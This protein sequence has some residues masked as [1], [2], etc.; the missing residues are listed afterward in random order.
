MKK[1]KIW[2]PLAALALIL[3]AAYLVWGNC[4]VTVT[5]YA[6]TDSNLPAAFDGFRIVQISDLHNAEFGHGNSRLLKK[7]KKAEPD[8]IVLTGDLIDS[9]HTDVEVALDFV[10]EVVQI[11]PTYYVTGNHESRPGDYGLLRVQMEAAGVQV[12][13]NEKLLLEREG[14]TVTLLGVNDPCFT[15]GWTADKEEGIMADAVA[16]LEP[17]TDYSILLAHK[18]SFLQVYADSGIDLVLSGHTHGGQFRLPF[19][20]GLYTP[21]QGLFPDYDGGL[22]TQGDTTLIISRGLGNSAFPLRLNNPPELVV[23]QLNCE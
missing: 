19:V 1:R 16:A 2:L 15:P 22:M 18:P 5:D 12:L 6:V 20:G 17:G 21:S 4:A 10:W 9:Y 23:V 14:D 7:I 3:L 8:M 13:E 11:A